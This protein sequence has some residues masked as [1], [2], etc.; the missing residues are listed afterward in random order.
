M[1]SKGEIIAALVALG[2]KGRVG[3]FGGEDPKL[4]GNKLILYSQCP[5][6]GYQF[7]DDGSIDCFYPDEDATIHSLIYDIGYTMEEAQNIVYEPDH[8]STLEKLIN[9]DDGWF[10]YFKEEHNSIIEAVKAVLNIKE[11][12]YDS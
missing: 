7:N 12:E 6:C 8:Y 9:S 2:F 3:P 10:Y 1:L 4:D 11:I 5:D